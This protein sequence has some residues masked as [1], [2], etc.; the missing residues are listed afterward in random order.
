MSVNTDTIF[1]YVTTTSL[2]TTALTHNGHTSSPVVVAETTVDTSGGGTASTTAIATVPADSIL[3]D[4]TAIVTATF[5][6]DS[7]T[8]FEVGITGNTDKYVDPS[9]LDASAVNSQQSMIGGTN[10]DQKNPEYLAAS[11]PIIATW[12]NTASASAGSATVRVVY[13][14]LA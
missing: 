4:V 8:T 7:T 6:G 14:P 2:S 11:T 1:T 3:I 12:T 9:D 13:I 5:D 10:N